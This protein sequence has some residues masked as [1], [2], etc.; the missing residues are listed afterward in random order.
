MVQKS[1]KDNPAAFQQV[2]SKSLYTIL[3][4]FLKKIIKGNF[5]NS[6]IFLKCSILNYLYHYKNKIK[7]YCN[8]CKNNIPGF[9]HAIS[10]NKILYNSICPHCSSRKRHRGL[11]ELYKSILKQY[12]NPNILHFAPEPVFYN[13][14]KSYN[15]KT[16]DIELSD[17]DLKL[18]I[19]HIHYLDNSFDIILCNHVLEHVDEDIK[20]LEELFRVLKPLGIVIITVPGDWT[21]KNTVEYEEPDANG[22]YRDYG[23]SI[24]N[25]LNA[26]FYKVKVIDLF[27]YNNNYHFSMGLTFQHDLAFICQKN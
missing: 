4:F 21:R 3:K 17:V 20:S 16:A 14:F 13:L 11:L 19:K 8:L 23:L 2:K 26:I 27:K 7:F 10:H 15:Y 9:L 25:D 1:T 22:H 6:I 5:I 24:L 18:D 12:K